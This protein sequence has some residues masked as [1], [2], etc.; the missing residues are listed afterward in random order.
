MP[1]APT[2][3]DALANEGWF[4]SRWRPAMC[5]LYFTVCASDF[6]LFP[7]FNALLQPD[8]TAATFHEW[9][10]LTLQGGGLFHVAMG[11]I[12]GSAVW[13]RTREKIAIYGGSSMETDNAAGSTMGEGPV[14]PQRSSRAD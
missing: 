7:I 2:E 10:P 6:I 8:A 9:R 1:D 3:P 14:M 11:G 4:N 13:T 12:V 5:W